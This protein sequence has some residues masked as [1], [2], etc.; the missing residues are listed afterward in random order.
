M[1]ELTVTIEIEL[2]QHPV[3]GRV[4]HNTSGIALEIVHADGSTARL[5]PG[6]SS[7][8]GEGE[9]VRQPA[10][11]PTLDDLV[12]ARNEITVIRRQW[13]SLQE[14]DR[15]SA[16]QL[17]TIAFVLGEAIDAW[18]RARGML[19]GQVGEI[20]MKYLAAARRP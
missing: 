5:P 4:V 17:A 12:D 1:K 9:S 6:A 18:M 10:P 11:P 20:L 16:T 19:P 13:A 14:P 2:D 15:L 8:L 7:A 3:T